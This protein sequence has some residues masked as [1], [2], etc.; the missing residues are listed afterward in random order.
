MVTTPGGHKGGCARCEDLEAVIR[1]LAGSIATQNV[2]LKALGGD[3]AFVAK[4]RDERIARLEAALR[5]IACYQQGID[6]LMSDKE[7]ARAALS[8]GG[9]GA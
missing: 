2:Q 4:L 8:R 1:V 3:E 6:N 5:V 7:I 9:D